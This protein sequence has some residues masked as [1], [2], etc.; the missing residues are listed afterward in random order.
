VNRGW[1]QVRRPVEGRAIAG[2]AKAL[3]DKF[4]VNPVAARLALLVLTFVG[5]AGIIIYVV[6]WLLLPA[7]GSDRP[8][9]RAALA[10]HATVGVTA[11]LATA[12]VALMFGAS[13][14]GSNVLLRAFSPG[15]VSIAALAA[16]WRNATEADRNAVG[17]LALALTSGGPAA[18][19]TGRRVAVVLAR[20]LAGA[21]LIALG[22]STILAPKHLNGTDIGIA[23]AALGVVAGTSLVLAPWWLRLA[24]DLATERRQRVRAEERAE[25]AAHIHDSVLQTL[26]L[27]Q[28]SAGDSQQVQ[29][30]ARAQ[31][32]ELRSWL[33]EE[34]HPRGGEPVTLAA[35][36]QSVQQ[37]VE[38]DHGVRVEVVVVGDAQLDESLGALVAAARE[39]AV[40]AAKWS[41]ADVVSVYAE[42]EPGEVSVFVRDRGKGFDP[43]LVAPDRRGLSES[44]H[45]RMQRHGG[46][47]TVRSEMGEGTEVT[48]VMPGRPRP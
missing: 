34:G 11:G 20:L 16:V 42:V 7:E 13:A 46:Q 48:L 4:D 22:T 15:V 32:R 10:D 3:A 27:I 40:N 36:L 6:A 28:R 23:F 41:G 35:A 9:W 30:L 44:V 5:G 2:V 8:I 18:A 19:P 33:F 31:E 24:R 43:Q 25:M 1:V 17:R 21:A 39:A 14:L 38:A 45:A 26:A 12:L 29:R 47:A 37:D